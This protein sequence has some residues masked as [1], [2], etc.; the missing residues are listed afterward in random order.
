MRESLDA[1]LRRY[2]DSLVQFEPIKH[3]GPVRV[4]IYD[5][6]PDGGSAIG[7]Q[8]WMLTLAGVEGVQAQFVDDLSLSNLVDYEVLLYPQCNTGRSAGSYEFYEV[9]KR[10]VEEAGGGVLYGHN[11]VGN[12]RSEFGTQTAF[13]LIAMGAIARLDSNQAVV[14]GDHPITAG[15]TAGTRFEH[16]Y[17]DH[18]TVKP[19]RKGTAI[20]ADPDGDPIMVAGQQGQGRVIYD[21][22]I[23]LDEASHPLAATGAWHDVFM[24][25]I[26]WLARRK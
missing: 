7:E 24:N 3:E 26:Q 4:A 16:T 11:S 18:W 23:M 20:L 19:G 15:L 17:Y 13:P 1:C 21:G 14:V 25:A 5:P 22:T 10:Y 8:S 2:A 9:I 6:A 12:E